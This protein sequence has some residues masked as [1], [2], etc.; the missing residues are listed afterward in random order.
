MK[1]KIVRRFFAAHLLTVAQTSQS[2]VSRVSKPASRCATQPTWKS[3]LRQAWMAALPRGGTSALHRHI[4]AACVALA[5]CATISARAVVLSTVPM[6]GTMLMPEVS[7]HAETDSVTVDLSLITEVAQL[8]PLLVSNPADRFDPADPWYDCLDPSRQGLAFSR[9]YGFDIATGS[10]TLP[11]NRQ[12]WIRKLSASPGLGIYDF[13]PNSTPK[14][15]T[16]IFGTAG[17][18]NATPWSGN[19]WHVGVTAQPGTNTYTATFEVYVVN[20]D[21]MFEVAGSS[22]PPFVLDW[23]DVPDGRPHLNITAPASG[24]L[25]LTWPATATNWAL[26]SA[27]TANPA[28]WSTVT[29]QPGILDGQRTVT[30]EASEA[31]RFFRMRYA[32]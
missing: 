20:T 19:M 27:S 21:T 31:S 5:G 14:R 16:P 32:P 13:R 17:T 28:S 18:S 26:V 3:A 15:W 22:S 11:D 7:Y 4:A 23:T 2:A 10:D 6:Q 30:L 1:R 29:N 9:R 12:L 8:T 25:R 24:Q